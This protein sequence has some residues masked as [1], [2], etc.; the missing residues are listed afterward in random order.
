MGFSIPDFNPPATPSLDDTLYLI[1]YAESPEEVDAMSYGD[2]TQN[3]TEKRYALSDISINSEFK[4]TAR[5]RQG[6][7]H[8]E[9]THCEVITEEPTAFPTLDP[10]FRPTGSPTEPP[11]GVFVYDNRICSGNRRCECE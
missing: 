10:T 7:F 4:M 3:V 5:N 8:G 11:V 1:S 2:M 9:W 6:T